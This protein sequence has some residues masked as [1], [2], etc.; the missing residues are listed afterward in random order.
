MMKC[1]T[2]LEQLMEDKATKAIDDDDDD[3][4]EA[5]QA[6]ADDEL[7]STSMIVLK[8][9]VILVSLSPSSS[10]LSLEVSESSEFFTFLTAVKSSILLESLTMSIVL[11]LLAIITGQIEYIKLKLKELQCSE[12]IIPQLFKDSMFNIVA[13]LTQF[14]F[15]HAYNVT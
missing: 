6:T 9:R 4:F 14:L 7:S 3:D 12:V 5:R 15:N 2:L 13:S 10:T 1:I 8:A 11:I